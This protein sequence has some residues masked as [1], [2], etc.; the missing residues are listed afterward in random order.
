[1]KEEIF[2]FPGKKELLVQNLE[3]ENQQKIEIECREI[4]LK[5]YDSIY[6]YLNLPLLAVGKNCFQVR[7]INK[8]DINLDKFKSSLIQTI[9]NHPCFQSRL[10]KKNEEVYLKY[11]PNIEPNIEIKN[12]KDC[13]LNKNIQENLHIF[14]PFDSQLAY[15]TILLS[16]SSLYLIVDIYHGIFDGWSGNI[17]WDSL[18]RAYLDKKLPYD[19]YFYF[20]KK[21]N[22]SKKNNTNE[23]FYEKNYDKYNNFKIKYDNNIDSRIKNAKT[24]QKII[25]ILNFGNLYEKLNTYF[26]SISKYNIFLAMNILLTLYIFSDYKNNYQE[27]YITFAGRNWKKEMYNIG[28]HLQDVPFKYYFKNGKINFKDFFENLQIQLNNRINKGRCPFDLSNNRIG[29][30]TEI[31]NIFRQNYILEDKKCEVVSGCHTE[32]NE[33]CEEF[34]TSIYPRLSIGN[35]RAIFIIIFNAKLYNQITAEKFA[36]ISEKVGYFIFENIKKIDN[37]YID[38]QKELKNI[39]QKYY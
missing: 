19:Y 12:I 36:D 37:N 10:F 39:E 23:K 26:D 24:P 5:P 34:V 7:K 17:F 11:C 30:I 1:M 9:K 28:F 21:Y 35:N 4:E 15:F 16:E 3:I 38:I 31:D 2:K 8:K 33:K 25:K 6:S 14:Q 20:L 32:I 27:M 18:S 13:D 22:D 29:G